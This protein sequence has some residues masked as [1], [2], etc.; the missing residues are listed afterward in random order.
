MPP[1]MQAGMPNAAGF[2]QQQMPPVGQAPAFPQQQFAP[3]LAEMQRRIQQ[4][5]DNNRQLTSQLAQAQQQTQA[6][7]ER[8]ELYTKQLADQT[9]QYRQLLAT[10]QQYANQ[11]LGM[12]A[13][14][15]AR[16]GAKLTA[17][18]SL[19]NSAAAV[20]IAGANVIP[21]GDVIRIRFSSDQLFA[22]GTAQVNPGAASMLDQLASVITRQFP[23]QRVAIE[24]HTDNN[25]TMGNAYGNSYQLS[26]AQAQAVL[27]QL[28]GR[29]RV[30]QQQLFIVAHGPNHPLADNQTPAGRAENRRVEVVIYPETY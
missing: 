5:D 22:P 1:N 26:G 2:P 12:Q 10:T 16:G 28:V 27:D 3:Q 20:R 13:S 24:G 9:A 30:P 19:A 4:L 6:L 18:N 8:N 29:N 15:T 7:R 25:S 14:M 17:N 11:A 21:D 23:R